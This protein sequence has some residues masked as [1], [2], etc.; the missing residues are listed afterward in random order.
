M[1]TAD[2]GQVLIAAPVHPLLTDG[3]AG[4]GYDCLMVPGIDQA[5]AY[6]LLPACTGIVTST[7]VVLDKALL[8]TAPDLKWIARMGSGMEIVDLAYAAGAGISCF[9]S[10]DGNNN[11]VGEHAVGMLLALLHRISWGNAEMKA[12]IWQREENRG[13]ELEGRT[14]GIVGYGHTGSA[15]ARKLKGFD[16]RILAYD[17]YGQQTIA[18]GDGVELISD[19][20]PIYEEADILSFHVPLTAETHKYFDQGFLDSMK[21][22]FIL[23]NT[24]RGAVVDTRALYDGL[25]SGKISGACLDV[26]AYEP[27]GKAPGEVQQM[28]EELI[29]RANVI[30]TPHIAGYTHDALRKMSEILLGKVAE[31]HS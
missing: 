3:L 13:W 11:A 12:G 14:V 17:K 31:L 9:S 27:P 8:C 28:M 18:V 2:R 1:K 24:S 5:G 4:L 19:L 29:S 15:F 10:P 21:R 6:E 25:I 22:P 16:V 7:R 30:V 20:A 23:V 26:Y